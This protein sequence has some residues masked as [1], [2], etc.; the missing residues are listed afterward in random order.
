LYFRD[1]HALRKMDPEA[2][3]DALGWDLWL[4]Q[5]PAGASAAPLSALDLAAMQPRPKG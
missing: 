4:L 3:R 1:P 5:H 2:R